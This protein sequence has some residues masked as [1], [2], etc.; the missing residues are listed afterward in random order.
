M[1]LLGLL[2]VLAC[3]AMAVDAVVQNGHVL[4]ATAFNQPIEHLTLGGIFVAG[5]VLGIVFA[6]GVLMIT[7]GL[8]RSRR[9]RLERRAAMRESTAEAEALRTHNERLE[10][11][12]EDQRAADAYPADN[13]VTTGD[14]TGRRSSA[15]MGG[16]HRAGS[17]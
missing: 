1:I 12:L 7:G 17:S 14:R 13:D 9:R 10:R 8:G 15:F 6:L 11:E 16:R 3:T 2:L 5:A 4:H